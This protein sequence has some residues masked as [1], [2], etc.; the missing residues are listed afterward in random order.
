MTTALRGSDEGTRKSGRFR[1]MMHM[2]GVLCRVGVRLRVDLVIGARAITFQLVGVTAPSK[3]NGALRCSTT[4]ES[5]RKPS[6]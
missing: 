3:C 5:Q 4:Q 1:E 2:R 6:N